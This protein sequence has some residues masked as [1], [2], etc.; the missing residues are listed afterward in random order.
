MVVRNAVQ[1]LLVGNQTT[2]SV[3]KILRRPIKRVG[4]ELRIQNRVV[5][6]MRVQ[7]QVAA[8]PGTQ[9]PPGINL[10]HD[11]HIG[12]LQEMLPIL[13]QGPKSKSHIQH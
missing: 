5:L 7:H 8:K 6:G 3:V 11:L 10:F 4:Y 13:Y 12:T 2:I 1:K 9:I